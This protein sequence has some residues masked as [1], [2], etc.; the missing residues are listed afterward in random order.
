[1]SILTIDGLPK[2][3]LRECDEFDEVE[4]DA[5]IVDVSPDDEEAYHAAFDE[6]CDAINAALI[7]SGVDKD[8]IDWRDD[9]TLWIWHG[10][11]PS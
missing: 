3:V 10:V 4:F 1:M 5:P 11:C 9:Q 6:A 8:K 2:H 7:A